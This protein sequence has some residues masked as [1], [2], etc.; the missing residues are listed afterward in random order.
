[1]KY[2]MS[3][4]WE[5]FSGVFKML[6]KHRT[7]TALVAWIGL[8]SIVGIMADPVL[9]SFIYV[10]YGITFT[11]YLIPSAVYGTFNFRKWDSI[12]GGW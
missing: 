5:G 8:W 3:K 9:A 1:M 6:W 2:I 7:I 12:H 4:F 10:I 11:M